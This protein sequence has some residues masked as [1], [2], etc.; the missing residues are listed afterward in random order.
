MSQPCESLSVFDP[1]VEVGDGW[2]TAVE[3]DVS[4][5][6]R[7]EVELTLAPSP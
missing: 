7:Q 3:V 1:A 6:P 4:L 2:L 5:H